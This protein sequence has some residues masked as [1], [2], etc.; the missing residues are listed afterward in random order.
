MK[1][2]MKVGYCPIVWNEKYRCQ[3]NWRTILIFFVQLVPGFDAIIRSLLQLGRLADRP[4]GGEMLKAEQVAQMEE[5]HFHHD[6]R[7]QSLRRT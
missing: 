5:V 4:A 3:M 1:L 6:C 2:L 7:G